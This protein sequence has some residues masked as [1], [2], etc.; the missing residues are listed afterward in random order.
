MGDITMFRSG[1]RELR[2]TR[3]TYR[4]RERIDARWYWLDDEGTWRPTKKGLSIAL[5]DLDEFLDN[6]REVAGLA[7][8]VA[9]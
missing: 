9:A 6:V 2:I 3:S 7:E 4:G 5:D 1:D 8:E